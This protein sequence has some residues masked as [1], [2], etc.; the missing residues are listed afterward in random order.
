[1]DRL[2]FLFLACILAG[3]ALIKVTQYDTLFVSLHTL[4]T[5]IGVL[6]VIVFSVVLIIKGVLALIGK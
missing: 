4:L 6:S 1:M 2:I 5:I 3:F